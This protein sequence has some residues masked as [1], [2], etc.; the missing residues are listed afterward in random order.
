MLNIWLSV[1]MSGCPCWAVI[2]VKRGELWN[3]KHRSGY[4]VL[5]WSVK[6]G[7]RTCVC[8]R[9]GAS[10]HKSRIETTSVTK[11]S[12]F[13]LHFHVT[14]LGFIGRRGGG[15]RDCQSWLLR[16]RDGH[17][18]FTKL[19]FAP[20]QDI[21][22]RRKSLNVRRLHKIILGL[23]I[24][25]PSLNHFPPLNLIKKWSTFQLINNQPRHHLQISCECYNKIL[26]PK[27]AIYKRQFK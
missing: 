1:L 26:L 24:L 22:W 9:S 5:H 17:C 11:A 3:S 7:S 27:V 18:L 6:S 20:M 14:S 21:W 25:P 19:L 15:S 23:L 2:T 12:W 4:S 10:N 8:V 16:V 13:L